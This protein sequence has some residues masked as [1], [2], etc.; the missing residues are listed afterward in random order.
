MYKELLNTVR[1]KILKT[2]D[3][4][5]AEHKLSFFDGMYN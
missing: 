5:D 4:R 3:I 2:S 1:F